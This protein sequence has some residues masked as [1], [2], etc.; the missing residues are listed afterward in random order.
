MKFFPIN[1][2]AFLPG[3]ILLPCLL[4]ILFAFL[5]SLLALSFVFCR[6]RQRWQNSSVVFF[7]D[8]LQLAG[9]S[10]V[11]PRNWP[12]RLQHL[13][14]AF[15]HTH[16]QRERACVNYVSCVSCAHLSLLWVA[17]PCLGGDSCLTY[18][19]T[20]PSGCRLYYHCY[21]LLLPLLSLIAFVFLRWHSG[22]SKQRQQRETARE[23]G[24]ESAISGP[25]LPW[26][27]NITLRSNNT[28]CMQ[29]DVCMYVA[30]SGEQVLRIRPRR[31]INKRI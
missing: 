7:Q 9:D 10:I 26:W 15:T 12:T 31:S 8:F 5:L 22:A 18:L 20:R 28:S 16:T 6:T 21:A 30:G 19:A 1:L 24:R 23:R 13:T 25:K 2:T 4:Y 11:V 27:G 29:N 14:A 3:K 17:S